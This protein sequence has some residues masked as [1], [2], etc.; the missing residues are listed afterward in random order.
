[1]E[2]LAQSLGN[3][4]ARWNIQTM[5]TRTLKISEQINHAVTRAQ[6]GELLWGEWASIDTLF[7]ILFVWRNPNLLQVISVNRCFH[8]S[9]WSAWRTWCNSLNI[10]HTALPCSPTATWQVSRWS[11][12]N[13]LMRKQNI[14]SLKPDNYMELSW[15]QVQYCFIK[16]IWRA[17]AGEITHNS[18]D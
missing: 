13:I 16:N 4:K 17:E 18:S 2:E 14:S 9:V 5:W 12:D 3:E 8:L 1:M 7:V 11:R 15:L 6:G 10:Q